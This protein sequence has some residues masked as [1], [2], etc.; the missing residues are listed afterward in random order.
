MKKGNIGSVSVM[1]E[2]SQTNALLQMLTSI[3]GLDSANVFSQNAERL[4][5]KIIKHGRTF[6]D[7]G[8]DRVSVYF[9]EIEAS[10]LIVLTALYLAAMQKSAHDYFPEIGRIRKKGLGISQSAE[11][12]NSQQT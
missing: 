6:T 3:A 8:T 4:K 9:Y 11:Q 5:Q 7:K 2:R 12:T 1:L 10:K